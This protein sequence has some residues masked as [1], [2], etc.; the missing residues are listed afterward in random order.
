MLRRW[1]ETPII[2]WEYDWM[3]RVSF[4]SSFTD[5]C[6][7]PNLMMY[8]FT[9]LKYHVDCK[10]L[11]CFNNTLY[12]LWTTHAT[13]VKSV[14][15]LPGDIADVEEDSCHFDQGP[16]ETWATQFEQWTKGP[17]WFRVY[18]GLFYPVMWE[19]FHKP[20]QGSLWN[21]QYIGKYEGFFVA[22]LVKNDVTP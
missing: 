14:N 10:N 15:F 5:R 12:T 16:R 6:N 17:W 20:L 21:N 3:P 8:R 9:T 11:D 7:I 2:I 13:T 4:P 19:L 18:R 22:Q 1:L